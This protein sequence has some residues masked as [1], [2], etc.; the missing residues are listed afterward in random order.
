MQV[1]I[2][3]VPNGAAPAMAATVTRV[4]AMVTLDTVPG[5]GVAVTGAGTTVEATT[6]EATTVELG[7]EVMAETGTAATI[8]GS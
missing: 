8:S 3:S 7:T 1:R 6:V 4:T 2:P 5:M